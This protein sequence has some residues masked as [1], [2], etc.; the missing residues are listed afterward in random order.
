MRILLI[1]TLYPPYSVGGAERSVKILAEGL[2]KK[3]HRVVVISLSDK[4]LI[5]DINGVKVYRCK[6][7]NVYWPFNGETKKPVL[8]SLWHIVDAY[9]PLMC[10]KVYK[11][12]KNEKPDIIH[13]HN[14]QGF[15][16]N[17]W[18]IGEQSNI[19][20]IHTLRDYW[21]RCPKTTM[22]KNNQ[23]C[24]SSCLD[25]MLLSIP[26]KELSQKVDA[27][28][29]I[30]QFILN[31]HIKAGYFK[32][33]KDKAVIYNSI[34][35]NKVNG[36]NKKIEDD[37]K[38]GFLGRI[39]ESKGIKLLIDKFKNTDIPLLIGGKGDEEILQYLT[40]LKA[41]NIK[42]LGYV[43]PSHFFRNIDI[44][45]VPSLWNEPFGRI[46][47][48][49]Y[50]CGVPVIVN[51]KG[52]LSEIVDHE[53]SGII[54]DFDKDDIIQ[55]VN[56]IR[57]NEKLLSDMKNAAIEKAKSFDGSSNDIQDYIKLYKKLS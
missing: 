49:A 37:F 18:K 56:K 32:N 44:L 39:S 55:I 4:E 51:D 22:Y 29:G 42:Y 16:S 47:I 31:S 36:S 30:S 13:T 11:I 50:G 28:V 33:V 15:S 5:E 48:E 52:G 7:E 57:F 12:I 10:K 9:N 27:V 41:P 19:P 24:E 21:L 14:L 25:C 23:V 8:H 2:V 20:N 17:I 46:V 1:N 35:I 53:K 26:K 40:Q 43:N 6:L 34:R 54:I 3:G 38:V 45:I